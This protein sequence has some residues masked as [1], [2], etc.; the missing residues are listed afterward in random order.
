M[1]NAENQ[2]IKT[3]KE[4]AFERVRAKHPDKNFD[5][6]EAYYGQI[7][8]EF[9]DGDDEIAK[10]KEREQVFSDMFTADPRAAQFMVNWRNGEDPTIGLVRMFGTEIKDAIDDPEMMEQ[11]AEANKEYVERVAKEREY[12][13]MYK[14]NI[15]ATVDNMD[16][17]QKEMGIADDKI[18]EAMGF[19]QAIVRDGVLGKFTPE[20]IKMAVKA[21]SHDADVEQ[22][23]YE[24]EVKGRNTKIE[25]KLRKDKKGDGAVSLS[26]KNNN[27]TTKPQSIPLFD[28]AREA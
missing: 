2:P 22:A 18:E 8:E 16:A 15:E 20:S 3:K 17:V 24:G 9:V 21:I 23:A 19:L 28:L 1:K 5:N 25:E 11:I 14:A 27:V 13:E 26:G 12:E 4:I 7:V 6:D 10:Y